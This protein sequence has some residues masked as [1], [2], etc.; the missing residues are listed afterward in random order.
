MNLAGPKAEVRL[1]RPN[2][3]ESSLDLAQS[4]VQI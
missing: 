3:V 1:P 2:D 4:Y